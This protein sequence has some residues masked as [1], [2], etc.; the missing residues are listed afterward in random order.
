MGPE[1]AVNIIFRKQI[2]AS[3]DPDATRAQMIEGIR[4]TIDPY[5][6]AGNALIDDVIDPRETRPTVIRALE[7]SETKS[8]DRPRK[9]H[10]VMPV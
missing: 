2:E 3:E 6:A 9:K 4:K 7:M 8:V 5:I 1:G 10:G